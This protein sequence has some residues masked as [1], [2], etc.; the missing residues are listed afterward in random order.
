MRTFE[1]HTFA[2]LAIAVMAAVTF[3]LRA[4]G[5]GLMAHVAR[6]QRVRRMLDAMPGSII[7]ATVL[8]LVVKSGP[9]AMLAIAAGAAV[10][11][12]SR[13]EFLAVA[14]AVLMAALARYAGI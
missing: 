1:P 6:T 3:L 12:L 4:A 8:P 13:N 11:M 5:Y 7:A 9:L 2:M 14:A 10:M